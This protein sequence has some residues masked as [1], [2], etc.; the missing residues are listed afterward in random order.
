[1]TRHA[2]ERIDT[3]H[4]TDE[5]GKWQSLVSGKCEH[6][7]STGCQ[8]C[9]VSGID[10]E[11]QD[12]IQGDGQAPRASVVEQQEIR[13]VGVKL[14]LSLALPEKTAHGRLTTVSRGPIQNS[15][16][17]SMMIPRITFPT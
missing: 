4:A 9:D 1:M 10:Q 14:R 17:T 2:D 7:S 3:Y 6:L 5:L 13:D 11:E 15:I 16:V 8:G 12:D